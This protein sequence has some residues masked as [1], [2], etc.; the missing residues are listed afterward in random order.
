[1]SGS[2]RE[3]DWNLTGVHKELVRMA[4]DVLDACRASPVRLIAAWGTALGLRR[5]EGFIPWDDDMDFW[6]ESHQCESLLTQLRQRRDESGI[7]A[8]WYGLEDGQ[9][10][11]LSTSYLKVTSTKYVGVS[12]LGECLPI[13]IDVFPIFSF[14]DSEA[15]AVI[16]LLLLR[17]A[18][19]AIRSLEVF[20]VDSLA[21]KISDWI[22]SKRATRPSASSIV[23]GPYDFSVHFRL[24]RSSFVNEIAKYPFEGILL[25][26]PREIDE[27]L[28]WAFG[29]YEKLPPLEA[30][31][32]AHQ[33]VEIRA[34]G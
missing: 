15:G 25:D 34:R 21:R 22:Y 28:T 11:P 1:M 9:K 19:I 18:D 17:I 27:Y 4:V 26:A 30:Q 29:E 33:I 5:H 32:P 20:G 10:A 14:G 2:H 8:Y 31:Q 6:I 13:S 16:S 23:A 12:S 24:G 7:R 3:T